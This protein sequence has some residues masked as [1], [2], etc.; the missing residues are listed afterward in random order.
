MRPVL[1]AALA[2]VLVRSTAE[3]A[4]PALYVS[5]T[6]YHG[7]STFF[8]GVIAAARRHGPRRREAGRDA[9]GVDDE[10]VHRRRSLGEDDEHDGEAS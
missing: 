6:E 2:A 7:G 4:A 1:G 8:S 3:S 9:G 10:A 5:M